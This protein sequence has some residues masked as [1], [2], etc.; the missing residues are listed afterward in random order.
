VSAELSLLESGPLTLDDLRKNP[1]IQMF[2]ALDPNN[3]A[4]SSNSKVA[5]YS[6][7]CKQICEGG[8]QL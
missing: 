7:I 4:L 2:A 8:E 5:Y 3:T 1:L 6:K